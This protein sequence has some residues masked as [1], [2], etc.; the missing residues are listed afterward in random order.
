MASM[1]R[2]SG[3]PSRARSRVIRQF[4]ANIAARIPTTSSTSS[5]MVT[6]PAVSVSPRASTS[7]VARVSRRPVGTRSW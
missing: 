2:A 4:R 1:A 3:G 7:L 5:T 6:A